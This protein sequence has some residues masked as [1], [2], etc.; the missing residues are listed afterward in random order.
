MPSKTTL[1]LDRFEIIL[2][3][4]INYIT[5]TGLHGS[6]WMQIQHAINQHTINHIND[7]NKHKACSFWHSFKANNH[8]HKS[9]K[10]NHSNVFILHQFIIYLKDVYDKSNNSLPFLFYIIDPMIKNKINNRMD[11]DIKLHSF[12]IEYLCMKNRKLIQFNDFYATYNNFKQVH[13]NKFSTCFICDIYIKS[14]LSLRK[15]YLQINQSSNKSNNDHY[16]LRYCILE[17]LGN[18]GFKGLLQRNLINIFNNKYY[19]YNKILSVIKHLQNLKLITIKT[20]LKLNDCNRIWLISYNNNKSIKRKRYIDQGLYLKSF[21]QQRT[22]QKKTQKRN[23]KGF[24]KKFRKRLTLL[25]K[26][27]NANN[28]VVATIKARK[29][30]KSK[31]DDNND[32]DN[33]LLLESKTFSRLTRKLVTNN[34]IKIIDY[35]INNQCNN[36]TVYHTVLLNYHLNEK[37]ENIIK[38]ALISI[39]QTN[40]NNNNNNRK[41]KSSVDILEPP[42]KKQKIYNNKNEKD[43]Y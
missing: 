34:K 31:D 43:E 7:N 2:Q 9:I 21:Y 16:D 14:N 24:M 20:D 39:E 25:E 4:I 28:G 22:S 8:N 38:L 13:N 41:R 33:Q 35:K 26:Y 6:C 3:F 19:H 12:G 1:S 15:R 17:K 11:Q 18:S 40:N 36:R 27:I 30:L 29:Y 10:S 42:T 32:N 5:S 23:Q 37:D